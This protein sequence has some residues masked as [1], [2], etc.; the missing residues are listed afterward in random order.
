[1][2]ALNNEQRYLNA[3]LTDIRANIKAGKSMS[4]A[5]DSAAAGEKDKWLLFDIANRR[6]INTI[7]PSLE[8]E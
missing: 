5:M 2:Q 6:N 7:Y 8:W 1:V 4:D 3:V